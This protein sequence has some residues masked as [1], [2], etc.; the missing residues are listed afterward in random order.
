[1]DELIIH[2]PPISVIDLILAKEKGA[3]IIVHN[4]FEI[5]EV[6]FNHEK[7]PFQAFLFFC[8]FF[9]TVDGKEYSFR[10]CYSRGCPNNL[11]PHVSQAVMIANRYLQRDYRALE[12]AGVEV[13]NKLFTLETM[14]TKFKE[15]K[16]QFV[17][18]LIIDDYVNIA[19]EGNDISIDVSLEYLPA[20]ENFAHHKE[21]R[22]F[23]AGNFT[24]TYMGE[25]HICQRCLACYAINREKEEKQMALGLANNRLALIYEDFDLASIKYNKQFFN[26]VA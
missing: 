1:M 17:S 4:S 16:D 9:G 11:C 12:K 21:K 6:Q 5:N 25:S 19:K 15:Q 14:L 10:K 13:E 3:Q 18:T 23:L 7:H 24:V 26:N 22:M 8:R 20:V 2:T